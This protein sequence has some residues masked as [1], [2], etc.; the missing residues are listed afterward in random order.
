MGYIM[1]IE[2]RLH[3]GFIEFEN[4]K[5]RKIKIPQYFGKWQYI[6]TKKK[7]KISLVKLKNCFNNS[8]FWE[9][10][11]F[12]GGLFEDCERFPKKKDADLRIK[13]IFEGL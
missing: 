6:Y 7:A 11:C 8:W 13:K 12:K 10:Y 5:K 9:I 3:E 1:E 4:A 2:K